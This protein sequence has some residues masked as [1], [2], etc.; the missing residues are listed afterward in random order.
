MYQAF[1]HNVAQVA[2]WAFGVA[3]A[4][5]TLA[6]V[7]VALTK[8]AYLARWR[9]W[10]GEPWSWAQYFTDLGWCV[11]ATGIAWLILKWP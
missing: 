2:V 8:K 1:R 7:K 6:G 4:V 3:S 5:F 10:T 11:L 9:E